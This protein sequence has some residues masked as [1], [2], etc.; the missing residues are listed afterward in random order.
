MKSRQK[1][2]QQIPEITQEKVATPETPQTD[3]KF[4]T[5][6]EEPAPT[7][8]ADQILETD[9]DQETD[10]HQ[11]TET[12]TDR[13]ETEIREAEAVNLTEVPEVTGT[14]QQAEPDHLIVTE[15]RIQAAAA[16]TDQAAETDIHETKPLPITDRQE[17][18]TPTD[19][20]QG[21]AIIQEAP[22]T[23]HCQETD[24]QTDHGDHTPEIETATEDNAAEH[25]TAKVQEGHN[26]PTKI[27]RLY[28]G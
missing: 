24:T 5:E 27:K 14:D 10:P 6:T 3:E 17:T 15:T 28:Q 4:K 25:Q 12:I 16:D 22:V 13:L 11:E 18:R 23:D 20:S 9:Q 21:Q 26:R 1:K 2:H 8:R 7:D 19:Q